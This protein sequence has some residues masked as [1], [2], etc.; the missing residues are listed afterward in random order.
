MSSGHSPLSV[1]GQPHPLCPPLQSW[2]GG[3]D[4]M[5]GLRPFKLPLAPHPCYC[6]GQGFCPFKL[7]LVLTPVFGQGLANRGAAPLLDYPPVLMLAPPVLGAGALPIP[8]YPTSP[9]LT[10]CMSAG[11]L[12]LSDTPF[13]PLC[14]QN[15]SR[16]LY[17]REKPL[18]SP[19]E[20][21][22]LRGIR[23]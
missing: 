7:P 1:N 22:G 23:D 3:G 4:L 17:E 2:R 14:S 8:N 18:I 19:F 12:P 21:G 13:V 11:A 20:K 10:P 9:V 16:S 6:L 15:S 5:K